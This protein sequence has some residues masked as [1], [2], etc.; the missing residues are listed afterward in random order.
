MYIVDFG[1][2]LLVLLVLLVTWVI[3]GCVFLGCVL[4]GCGGSGLCLS[5]L[6]PSTHHTTHR[7]KTLLLMFKVLGRNQK[8]DLQDLVFGVEL[9]LHLGLSLIP[10]PLCLVPYSLVLF[11]LRNLGEVERH[12]DIF[13][14]LFF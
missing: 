11:L 2:V 12:S 14:K 13:L 3:S 10:Y 1:G 7:D 8:L 6:C 4:P 9:H 5:R